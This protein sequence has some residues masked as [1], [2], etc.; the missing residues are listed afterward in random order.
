MGVQ[1]FSQIARWRFLLLDWRGEEA[2]SKSARHIRVAL[3]KGISMMFKNGI[4]IAIVN[5]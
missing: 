3:F 4:D 5:S 1:S 2:L